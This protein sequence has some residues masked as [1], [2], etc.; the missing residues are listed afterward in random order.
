MAMLFLA[1][2]MA[3]AVSPF[4]SCLNASRRAFWASSASIL[5]QVTKNGGCDFSCFGTSCLQVKAKTPACN[6]RT[7]IADKAG[8]SASADGHC[9]VEGRTGMRALGSGLRLGNCGPILWPHTANMARA[10][11]SLQSLLLPYVSGESVTS[12]AFRPRQRSAAR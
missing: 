1:H 12:I 4:A 7:L 6:S 9:C 2:L 8:S 3:A 5:L 10:Y 11:V